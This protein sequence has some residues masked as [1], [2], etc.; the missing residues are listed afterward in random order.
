VATSTLSGIVGDSITPGGRPV[1]GAIVWSWYE[2]GGSGRPGGQSSTDAEGR[3]RMAAPTGV[4][5]VLFADKPGYVQPCLRTGTRLI[6][7]SIASCQNA[8]RDQL[9]VTVCVWSVDDDSFATF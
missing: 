2:A 7:A 5:A 3:Y 9:N 4:F 8:C 6:L 1:A